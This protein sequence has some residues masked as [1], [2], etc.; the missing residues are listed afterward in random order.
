MSFSKNYQTKYVLID[1]SNKYIV[2]SLSKDN[3]SRS[4]SA[5]IIDISSHGLPT[6]PLISA[7]S[8]DKMSQHLHDIMFAISMGKAN[9]GTIEGEVPTE[10]KIASMRTTL[11]FEPLSREE[12]L[13]KLH[14]EHLENAAEK[15]RKFERIISKIN[16]DKLTEA[17]ISRIAQVVEHI[18]D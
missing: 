15:Q 17:D 14:D 8:I 4:V 12:L 11:E 16:I 7:T 13:S 18:A 9:F 10:F 2:C 6:M 5:H 3:Y 1:A